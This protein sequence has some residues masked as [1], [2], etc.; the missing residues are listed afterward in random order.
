[1]ILPEA[2]LDRHIKSLAKETKTTPEAVM[3]ITTHKAELLVAAA[4]RA[5]TKCPGEGDWLGMAL[6]CNAAGNPHARKIIEHT[7][8]TLWK[9]SP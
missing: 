9:A 7:A 2:A 3:L 1:M 5:E 4:R 6:A 8:H